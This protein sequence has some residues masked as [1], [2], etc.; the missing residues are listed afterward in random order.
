[1]KYTRN[2]PKGIDEVVYKKAANI[3]HVRYS[4]IN[5]VNKRPFESRLSTLIQ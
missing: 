4:F 3:I 1:M 5:K 2:S